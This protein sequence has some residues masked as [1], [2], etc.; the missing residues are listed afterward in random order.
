METRSENFLVTNHG[1]NQWAD[2][3]VGADEQGR[4]T[5]MRA[6]VI[7]D[8]GAYPKALDLAWCTWVM[9]TGPYI[10]PN[11]D[12]NVTGVYTNTMANGAYRGAGR[13]EAAFYLERVMDMIADAGALDPAEVRRANF[14]PRNSSRTPRSRARTM[15]P[16]NTTS[17]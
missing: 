9:S 6:R 15:T 1:R 2:F 3:E 17:R 12:Y 13:P 16:A 7:L 5:G 11:L 4:I 8:S 10:I 14:I